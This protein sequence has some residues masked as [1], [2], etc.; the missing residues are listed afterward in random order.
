MDTLNHLQNFRDPIWTSG[1]VE[2]FW[3]VL[4]PYLTLLLGK[5]I[6]LPHPNIDFIVLDQDNVRHRDNCLRIVHKYMWNGKYSLAVA[7]F[8][9]VRAFFGNTEASLREQLKELREVFENIPLEW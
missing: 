7:N 9:A 2:K 1:E 5:E 4:Q 6:R 8:K 3:N